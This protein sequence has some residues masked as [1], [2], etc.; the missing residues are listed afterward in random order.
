MI[1]KITA[2]KNKNYA[3]YDK[4]RYTLIFLTPSELFHQYIYT[5]YVSGILRNNSDV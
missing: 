3:L 5:L 2:L 4:Y 1:M